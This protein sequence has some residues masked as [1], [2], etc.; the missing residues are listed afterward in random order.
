MTNRVLLG[1]DFGTQGAKGVLCD[2]EGHILSAAYREHTIS[3]P[4]PG[5]A[6]QDAERVWWAAFVAL[7]RQLPAQANLSADQIAA[8][9]VSAFVPALLPVD[10]SG[11]P[12]RPAILYTDRR[13]QKQVAALT[14]QLQQADLSPEITGPVYLSSPITQLLW[15]REHEPGVWQRTARIFQCH[16]YLVYRLT[17]SFV[18]DQ[19]MKRSY[20]PL[21]DAER[22]GWSEE[23]AQMLGLN[24]QL[25]PERIAWATQPAGTITAQAAAETGLLEGTPVAVGTAD[26]F[27]DMIGSGTVVPGA[28]VALYG[29]F[30]AVLVTRSSP[31]DPWHG[32]HCL[33]DLYFSGAAVPTGA[34]LTRWFR[35]TF[36]Q[37]EMAQERTTGISAYYWLDQMAA[38]VPPG[39]DGLIAIPDF[40]GE[41]S[42]VSSLLGRGALIGLTLH[43]GR[44]HVYRALLEGIAY[45][46][47]RQLAAETTLPERIAA[48][49][50]GTASLVWTQVMSDVLGVTQ[51]VL[52]IPYSA[53]FGSAYLAGMAADLFPDLEKLKKQWI[54]VKRSVQPDPARRDLYNAYYAAY[55]DARRLIVRS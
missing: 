37:A 6:E 30:T 17:G 43:H 3:T 51:E 44:A 20:V 14:N 52:D 19:A 38:E 39:C 47:R 45:E 27:A 24:V 4:Q 46:L 13:D 29:S 11:R 25:L 9:G 40:S 31:P 2:L 5:W 50:G 18:I 1:I 55:C 53:P 28:A 23:R 10:K 8:I 41:K 42:G 22:E 16:N 54:R 33:P 7:T 32:Y 48:V 49:A 34:V 15:L 36:G 12:L 21:Y 26:A 35:D